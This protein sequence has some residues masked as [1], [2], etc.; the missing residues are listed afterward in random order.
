MNNTL[1]I[2]LILNNVF[3]Y[4]NI[5]Q[6]FECSLVCR[7]WYHSVPIDRL[8]KFEWEKTNEIIKS[9]NEPPFKFEFQIIYDKFCSSLGCALKLLTTKDKTKLIIQS[10]NKKSTIQVKL[11]NNCKNSSFFYFKLPSCFSIDNQTHHYALIGSDIC[12]DFT[13]LNHIRVDELKSSESVTKQTSKEKTFLDVIIQISFLYS[14]SNFLSSCTKLNTQLLLKPLPKLAYYYHWRISNDGTI[15]GSQSEDT[16]ASFVIFK[17]VDLFVSKE[18][19]FSNVKLQFSSHN[20][21][22]ICCN[23]Y[24]VILASNG[25]CVFDCLSESSEVPLL[26]VN[27]DV[28]HYLIDFVTLT[29][30]H[31]LCYLGNENSR[32][33][34]YYII[35]MRD[36]KYNKII[37]YYENFFGRIGVQQV[38]DDL[39]H[40]HSYD[41]GKF[42]IDLNSLTLT[43]ETKKAKVHNDLWSFGSFGLSFE[44]RHVRG[45]WN[46]V[47][48]SGISNSF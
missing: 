26:T 33:F 30:T 34:H 19:S 25:F 41:Y 15:F 47:F 16:S 24:L 20:N 35:N 6:L 38:N 22:F 17:N 46:S 23:R 32:K 8:R 28:K 43:S 11:N 48:G 44:G 7:F 31:F 40:I 14:Y 1:F 45:G 13:D 5:D 39:V 3:Y 9:K 21:S 29:K 10:P 37:D 2:D 18:I 4:L 36:L 12:V 27:S 42:T